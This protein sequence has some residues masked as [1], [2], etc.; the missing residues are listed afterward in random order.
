MSDSVLNLTGPETLSVRG[1]CNDLGRLMNKT[2]AFVGNET[3]SAFL[4]NAAKCFGLYG[5][6]FVTPGQVVKWT[7]DWVSRGGESLGK[8]THFETRDGKY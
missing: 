4:N 6:P 8:P 3:G 1:V 7:A 2:P 5:Y